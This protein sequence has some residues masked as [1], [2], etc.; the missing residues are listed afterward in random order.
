M[1]M[2]EGREHVCLELLRSG[3]KKWL[4]FPGGAT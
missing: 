2:F 1:E 3:K 4:H